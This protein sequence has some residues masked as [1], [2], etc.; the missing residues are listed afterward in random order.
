MWYSYISLAEV[1][2]NASNENLHFLEG[3]NTNKY[4]YP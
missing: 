4:T 1:K 2:F 3:T